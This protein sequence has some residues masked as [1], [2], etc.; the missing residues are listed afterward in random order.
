MT[1]MATEERVA[2]VEHD[3]IGTHD[4]VSLDSTGLQAMEDQMRFVHP[5]FIRHV[6]TRRWVPFC[7]LLAEVHGYQ[8]ESLR[9]LASDRS[10]IVLA[11][12]A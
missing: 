4:G 7:L 10:R 6:V 5:P 12:A 2:P 3:L 9:S 11:R 1:A 8:L